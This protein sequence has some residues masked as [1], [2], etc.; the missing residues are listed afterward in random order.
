MIVESSSKGSPGF[1]LHL[2]INFDG[3]KPAEALDK[4]STRC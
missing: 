3:L 2:R 4:T 1:C